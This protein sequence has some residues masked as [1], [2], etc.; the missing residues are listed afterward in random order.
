[1]MTSSDSLTSKNLAQTQIELMPIVIAKAINSDHDENSS[2]AKNLC[3]SFQY[4]TANFF[5]TMFLG[6]LRRS[7]VV[8]CR[9][10]FG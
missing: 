9:L 2:T 6:K 7:F 1:M 10:S 8:E 5:C 4:T 3:I